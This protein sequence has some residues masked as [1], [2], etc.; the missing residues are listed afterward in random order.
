MAIAKV[1]LDANAL[2]L[3][4]ETG[5]R[6]EPELERLF[7]RYEVV[8]PESVMTELAK[9]AAEA[10]GARASNARMALSLAARYSYVANTGTGDGA[11]LSAAKNQGAFLFT[12]DRVLLKRAIAE[13][14][15]VVRLKGGGHLIV[16]TGQ[17]ESR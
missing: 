16:E 8:V 3:P 17:G 11:V 2:L 4:F 6:I 1:L 9:I 10:K 14:V 13:G 7:G 15:G 12:N 5:V